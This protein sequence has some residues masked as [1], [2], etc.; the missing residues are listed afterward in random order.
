MLKKRLNNAPV[1]YLVLNHDGIMI[2]SNLTFLQWMGYEN[3]DL[4]GQH[5]ESI[6]TLANKLIFHSYFYPSINIEKKVEEL[7]VN[8]RNQKGETVPFLL[9]AQLIEQE[10][11]ELIDCFLVKM[12]KRYDYEVE[13]RETK[14]LMEDAYLE[15]ERA[16]AKLQQIYFEIEDKQQQLLEINSNLVKVTNT[17]KLTDIYNRK[18]FQEQ[19]AVEVSRFMYENIGF[20]LIIL[21]IDHFKHVNDTY[22]HPIGDIA[23]QKLAKMLVSHARQQDIVARYGGE[24]F[25]IILPNTNV[26]TASEQATHLNQIVQNAEWEETGYLTISVG[27]ATFSQGD[28]EHSIIDK[29]DKALYESKLNGRNRVTHYNAMIE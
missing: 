16:L 11:V 23:L 5:M 26:K 27:V 15:K 7:F 28:S 19:L 8:F 18:F 9:N 10:G 17:D 24:E 20:S 2:E 12:K 14:R 22:G 25:V 1:G 3:E 21:D 29:A 6:L 4:V 13:L